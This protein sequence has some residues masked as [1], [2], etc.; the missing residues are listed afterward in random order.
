MVIFKDI[1]ISNFVLFSEE[2]SKSN[3]ILLFDKKYKNHNQLFHKNYPPFDLVIQILNIII[4]YKIHEPIYYQFTKDMIDSKNAS[5]KIIDFIPELE[6]YYLKCK[7]M[8]Y[9][10]NITTNKFIT[11]LKQIL[12]PYS[13]SINSKEKYIYGKKQI[14]YTIQKKRENNLIN[15]NTVIDFN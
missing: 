2:F 15:Y 5:K 9:L 10:K 12:K 14:L 13:Y 3:K 8:K 4:Q 7:H 6:K 1:N 11:I